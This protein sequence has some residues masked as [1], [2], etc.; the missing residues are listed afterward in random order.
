ELEHG[1]RKDVRSALRA[2]PAAFEH[3]GP[4]AGVGRDQAERPDG[5]VDDHARHLV[6]LERAVGAVREIDEG[7][8]AEGFTER[9]CEPGWERLAA[10]RPAASDRRAARAHPLDRRPDLA[11]EARA[12]APGPVAAR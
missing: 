7:L 10:A 6:N 5:T 12:A 8:D 4:Q 2:D 1:L 3:Q 11:H 9:L